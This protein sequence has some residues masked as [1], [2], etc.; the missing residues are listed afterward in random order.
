MNDA[1]KKF[2]KSCAGGSLVLDEA[3]QRWEAKEMTFRN[4]KWDGQSVQ[5]IKEQGEK[6]GFLSVNKMVGIFPE[7]PLEWQATVPA[8]YRGSVHGLSEEP[9]QKVENSC[10]Q[11]EYYV[12]ILAFDKQDR[13]LVRKSSVNT[14]TD[15][16]SEN[17]MEMSQHE[18]MELVDQYRE[19][20]RLAE[21][22]DEELSPA[23]RM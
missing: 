21:D 6:L 18:A 2:A 12:E 20:R 1:T 10:E 7:K 9:F 22:P 11:I 5:D 14:Y 16:E 13:A 19:E 23:F 17:V 4:W 15:G 8:E 3:E